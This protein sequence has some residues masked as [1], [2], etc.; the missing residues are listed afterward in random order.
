M[1]NKE[2]AHVNLKMGQTEAARSLTDIPVEILLEIL[3]QLSFMDLKSAESVSNY[4]R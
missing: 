2:T 1:C 4:I 3:N